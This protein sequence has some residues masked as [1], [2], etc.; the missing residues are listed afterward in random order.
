MGGAGKDRLDGG[1]G[2]HLLYGGSGDDYLSGGSGDDSLKGGRGTDK[3][4]GGTGADEFVLTRGA[5]CDVIMDFT[6]GQDHISYGGGISNVNIKNTARGDA[7]I[8]DGKDL[9]AVVR[10]AAGDLEPHAPGASVQFLV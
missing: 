5:G 3:V 10:G 7:I 9:L 6:D 1:L 8:Y 2:N 4:Y